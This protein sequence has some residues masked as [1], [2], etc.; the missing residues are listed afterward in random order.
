[1]E[2]ILKPKK[3]VEENCDVLKMELVVGVLGL[4]NSSM[5]VFLDLPVRNID[6]PSHEMYL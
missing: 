5:S 2:N 4:L 3:M 1:M 6:L